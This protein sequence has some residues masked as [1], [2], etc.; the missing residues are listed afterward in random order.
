MK[1]Y[2]QGNNLN[3]KTFHLRILGHDIGEGSINPVARRPLDRWCRC[4]GRFSAPGVGRRRQL[5]CGSCCCCWRLFLRA[6][7]Q[8]LPGGLLLNWCLK[9]LAIPNACLSWPDGQLLQLFTVR[10]TLLCIILRSTEFLV[11]QICIDFD[12]ILET[13]LMRI[14]IQVCLRNRSKKLKNTRTNF[15]PEIYKMVPYCTVLYSGFF[16]RGPGLYGCALLYA[17]I[18]KN[19]TDTY[20]FQNSSWSGSISTK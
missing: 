1:R 6:Q 7:V 20:F 19:I 8:L 15:F 4:L 12:A 16:G 9:G 14:L 17:E 3:N 18:Q 5:D 10:L 11:F 13:R 2:Q